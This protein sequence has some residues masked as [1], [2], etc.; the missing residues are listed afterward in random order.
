VLPTPYK[1][2]SAIQQGEQIQRITFS[3]PCWLPEEPSPIKLIFL[4]KFYFWQK[5]QKCFCTVNFSLNSFIFIF[6]KFIIKQKQIMNVGLIC[7]DLSCSNSIE[8][9]KT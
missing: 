9:Q 8:L 7:R 1:A 3:P 4:A 2:F 6:Y 5:V